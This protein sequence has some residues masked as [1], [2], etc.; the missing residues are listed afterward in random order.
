[1]LGLVEITAWHWIGFI[2]GV[3]F[4]LALDLGVFHREPRAIRFKEALVWTAIW[5]ALAML[6]AAA[7]VP[8]RGEQESALF[9]TGYVIELSLSM[10]NVFVMAVIFNYFQVPL[11][12][13]HRVLFWGIIGALIMRGL[14]IGLG[15]AA[16]EHFGWMLYLLG[17]FLVFSG[18]KMM[19]SSE[20]QVNPAKNVMLRLVRRFFP[21]SHEFDG[22]HFFT[23]QNGR[24]ML[25]P[26]ALVLVVVETTDLVFAVDSIPAIFGITQKTFIIFTSNIFA[27]LG[28]RS[29]YFV[30]ASAIRYFRYLKAGLSLVL[31]FIGTKMLLGIWSI[32]VP[33]GLSLGMVIGIIVSSVLLSLLKTWKEDRTE[34]GGSEGA[35]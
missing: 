22:S 19:L 28:L 2:I 31:V 18:I 27:I 25:T 34:P 9:F 11:F 1:M 5:F 21:I 3:G 10:D 7:L 30:L 26:L 15:A 14:F 13:Q 8:W 32:D 35:D 24:R 16:I 12:Q 4:L 29:L 33:T 20:E 17:A 6:F 23:V